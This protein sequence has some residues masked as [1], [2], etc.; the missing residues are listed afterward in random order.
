MYSE[1]SCN[2]EDMTPMDL[3][4]IVEYK[5]SSFLYLHNNFC[6]NSHGSTCTCQSLIVGTNVK[7][8]FRFVCRPIV[9]HCE[10][11]NSVVWSAIEVH[12]LLIDKLSN[13][14]SSISMSHLNE[15]LPR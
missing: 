6:Y 8:N 13:R 2:D 14:S 4:M 10:G 1:N 15:K 3:T 11:H 12:E 5:V 7:L 9:N